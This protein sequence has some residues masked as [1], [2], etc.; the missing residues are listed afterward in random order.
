MPARRTPL[1]LAA[2]L[3]LAVLLTGCGGGS[4]AGALHP[5]S[6]SASSAADGEAGNAASE[7]SLPA[8]TLDFTATTLAGKPFAAATALA[9]KQTVIW[10]W[11]PGSSACLAEAPSIQA[12]AARFGQQVTF[13][14]VAGGGAVDD[15]KKFVSDTGLDGFTHL[16]DTSRAI[17]TRFQVGHQPAFAF[18]KPGGAIESVAGPLTD[19]Q[20][21]DRITALAQP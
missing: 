20:L 5:G 12:V 21:S 8:S 2:T 17:S 4:T 16:I 6:A 15:L 3:T 14:G 19:E 7:A 11:A 13:V 10:F 9:G 1:V 18:V